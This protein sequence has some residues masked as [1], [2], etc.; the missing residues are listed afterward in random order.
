MSQILIA[1]CLLDVQKMS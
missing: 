1:F